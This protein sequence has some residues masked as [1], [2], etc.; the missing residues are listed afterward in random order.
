MDSLIQN[1]INDKVYSLKQ[2]AI[3]LTKKFEN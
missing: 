2:E 1:S 3:D